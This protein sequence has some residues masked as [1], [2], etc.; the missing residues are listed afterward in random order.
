MNLLQKGPE[1][2]YY[3]GIKEEKYTTVEKTGEMC[4]LYNRRTCIIHNDRNFNN[5]QK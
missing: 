1:A 4:E 2:E 3:L 5:L